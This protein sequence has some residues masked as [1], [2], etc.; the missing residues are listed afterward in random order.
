[1]EENQEEKQG[2]AKFNFAKSTLQRINDL[3]KAISDL[4]GEMCSKISP[5]KQQIKK[6]FLVKQLY[7]QS[8]CL[9]DEKDKPD[10][11]TKM[12]GLRFKYNRNKQEVYSPGL[13]EDLDIVIIS[14]QESMQKKGKF[15]TSMKDMEEDE[16]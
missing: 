13:N 3:L 11:K 7:V 5:I 10:I 12:E 4:D 1:M 8:I 9:L 16:F 15:F 14:I 6:R 2:E